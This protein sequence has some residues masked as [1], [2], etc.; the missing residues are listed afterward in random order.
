MARSPLTLAAL[1]TSAVAGFDVRRAV[2]FGRGSE[3]TTE[4]A[5][6][7][8]ADGHHWV[9]LAPVSDDARRECDA[10]VA[11]LRALSAGIRSRLPFAVSEVAGVTA[12]QPPAAVFSYLYGSRLRLKDLSAGVAA[13]Q[14]V[15]EAVAAIHVLPSG[16]VSDAGLPVRSAAHCQQLAAA[17]V[18]RADV[19]RLVPTVLLQRWSDAVRDGALWQFT[20]T[21]VHGNVSATSFVRE[22][23]RVAGMVG[24]RSLSVG[25]PA[26]DLGWVLGSRSATAVESFFDAYG[27]ARGAGDRQLARRA[28]LYSELEVARWL[29]HG[30]DRKDSVVIDD[31]VVLLSALADRVDGDTDGSITH[32]T[33]P[34]LAVDEVRAMLDRHAVDGVDR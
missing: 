26:S 25:D 8:T 1:A 16:F 10:E 2:P 24:W 4:S 9:V 30:S 20:P 21:V 14:P 18:E 15:A 12:G 17:V 3:G 29:L 33:L 27:V 23:V 32:A 34:V 19:T 11:A 6:V 22:G 7:T 28:R 5:L 31:A 13:M